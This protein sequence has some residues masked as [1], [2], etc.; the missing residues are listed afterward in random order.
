LG[1]PD[2]GRRAKPF[3]AIVLGDSLRKVLASQLCAVE[4]LEL[5]P[6]FLKSLLQLRIVVAG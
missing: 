3:A 5:R 4:W 2:R 6:S 1:S